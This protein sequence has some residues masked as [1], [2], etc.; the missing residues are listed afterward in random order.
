MNVGEILGGLKRDSKEKNSFET[1][2][3]SR[4]PPKGHP[5][6]VDNSLVDVFQFLTSNSNF[7]TLPN[8]QNFLF[9]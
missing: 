8:L 3:D 6:L 2:P 5:R 7:K 9:P 1:P 4:T